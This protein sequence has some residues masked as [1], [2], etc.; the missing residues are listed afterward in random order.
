M[1][2]NKKVV[3]NLMSLSCSLFAFRGT[4]RSLMKEPGSRTSI[5]LEGFGIRWNY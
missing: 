4:V 1:S 2:R 5:V 3:V